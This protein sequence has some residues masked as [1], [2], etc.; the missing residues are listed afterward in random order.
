MLRH[1][2]FEPYDVV[3][4]SEV[5]EHIVDKDNF[6]ADLRECLVPNGSVIVTTPRREWQRR[7]VRTRTCGHA[8][9]QSVKAWIS[10]KRLRL[11]FER[12]GFSPIRHDRAYSPER[13]M[14]LLHKTCAAAYKNHRVSHSL[15]RLGL[16]GTYKACS[17]Y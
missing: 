11:L 15:D 16:T 2:E 8:G 13:K 4:T 3:I 6:V 7:Y 9:G 17:K 1:L 10:E 14:G 5:I 12:F